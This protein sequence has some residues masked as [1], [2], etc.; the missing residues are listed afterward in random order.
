MYGFCRPVAADQLQKQ[1]SMDSK[2]L[3]YFACCVKEI[4]PLAWVNIPVFDYKGTLRSG[5][6]NLYMWPITD[7]DIL[8]E[9]L[10]NPIG[11][12]RHLLIAVLITWL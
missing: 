8:S 10:L 1:I 3:N 6:H 12:I 5:E 2:L 4:I 11:T 9:E 7:E